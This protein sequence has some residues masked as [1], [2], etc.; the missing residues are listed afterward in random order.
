M[1]CADFGVLTRF[2]PLVTI[3]ERRHIASAPSAYCQCTVGILPVHR[4]RI[5]SARQNAILIYNGNFS[6]K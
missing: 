4:R 2:H 3:C 6:I 5:A 1:G